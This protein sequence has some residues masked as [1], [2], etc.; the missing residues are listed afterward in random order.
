[1]IVENVDKASFLMTDDSPVYP[2][3]GREFAD[4]GWWR[5][6]GEPPF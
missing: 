1:M 2:G 6:A 3:I 5:P 4:P